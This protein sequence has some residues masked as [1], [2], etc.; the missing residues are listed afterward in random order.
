[1]RTRNSD[2]PVV[3]TWA[4]RMVLAGAVLVLIGAATPPGAV[5]ATNVQYFL[6]FYAGVFTLLAM[7]AAVMSG[8]LATDRLV[9]GIR[10]RVIA[11][12]VHRAAAALAMAMVIAHFSVKVLG[13]LARP[14]Q[15]VVPGA[16]PIGLGTIAFEAMVLIVITGM[17]RARFAFRGQPW[18]WR[19]MHS[20]S[21]A[22][23]PIAIVHGLTAGRSAANWVTLSYVLS[24]GGVFLALLTRMIVVVKPRDVRRAGDDLGAQATAGAG[25]RGLVDDRRAMT[26]D[27]RGLPNDPR[28]L[29]A[30]PRATVTDPRGMRLP[31]AG[32]GRDT[33][34]I[35]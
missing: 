9:L 15:I 26:G 35:R 1:M 11:Q 34:V 4:L 23:W 6:S 29:L 3:P 27:P 24:V 30:D 12:G 5:I 14:V 20:V 22:S 17:M 21:Y 16:N 19:I 7:T 28:E 25:Q 2:D 31:G 33:E 8:L 18:V 32:G 10:Q 13:G